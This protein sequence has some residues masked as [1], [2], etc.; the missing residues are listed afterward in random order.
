MLLEDEAVIDHQ[1]AGKWLLSIG[2]GQKCF[3][4]EEKDA[5]IESLKDKVFSVLSTHDSP[6]IVIV[7]IWGY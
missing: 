4:K 6:M 2:T 3:R 5:V 1:K 7:L